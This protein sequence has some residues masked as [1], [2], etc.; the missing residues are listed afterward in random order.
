MS[1]TVGM[2]FLNDCREGPSIACRLPGNLEVAGSR[3]QGIRHA[4]VHCT[5][6]VV[7]THQAPVDAV[8][9]AGACHSALI[10]VRAFCVSCKSDPAPPVFATSDIDRLLHA[11]HKSRQDHPARCMQP[12][13]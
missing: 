1:S 12:P 7:G 5:P 2:A 3:R 8:E 6:A 4:C 10:A 9:C 13:I 11:G